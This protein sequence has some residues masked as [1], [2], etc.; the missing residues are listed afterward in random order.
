MQRRG[1]KILKENG[2]TGPDWSSSLT[3]DFLTFSFLLCFAY[4]C[5]N[6]SL[7]NAVIAGNFKPYLPFVSLTL[8]GADLAYVFKFFNREKSRNFGRP[9]PFFHGEIAF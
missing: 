7:T 3:Q 8:Q 6:P 5:I 2:G 9:G 1:A 4:L